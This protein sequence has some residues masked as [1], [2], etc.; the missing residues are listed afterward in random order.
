M[1]VHRSDGRVAVLGEASL[2]ESGN[3]DV[4]G[5]AAARKQQT[6]DDAHRGQIVYGHHGGGAR[7]QLRDGSSCGKSSFEPQVAG[8]HR[9]GLEA[10]T[11]HR[12]FVGFET[13]DV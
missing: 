12:F 10:Q 4:L 5:D 6:F 13:F 7:R 3:R 2:V 9:P 11:L 1:D 8:Q